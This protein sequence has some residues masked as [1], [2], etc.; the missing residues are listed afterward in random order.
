MKKMK[1]NASGS[2]SD[3]KITSV[4]F[5]SSLLLLSV[6]LFGISQLGRSNPRSMLA[7]AGAFLLI[8]S[9]L[10]LTIVWAKRSF[11]ILN[12]QIGELKKLA[13]SGSKNFREDSSQPLELADSLDGVVTTNAA[14]RVEPGGDDFDSSPGARSLYDPRRLPASRI[15]RGNTPGVIGRGAAEFELT[16]ISHRNFSEIFNSEPTDWQEPILTVV[17]LKCVESLGSS[18][19][20]KRLTPNTLDKLEDQRFRYLIIDE[21][22]LTTG[23]WA[24]VLETYRTQLFLSLNA[25]IR[26]LRASG[27]VVILKSSSMIFPFT[28]TLRESADVILPSKGVD[29]Q[30]AS[31]GGG[32][33]ILRKLENIGGELDV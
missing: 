30:D 10:G 8:A 28:L 9:F 1:I 33:E 20:Q 13:L 12:H 25:L 4:K 32:L 5:L 27:T 2:G 18:Y 19:I 17:P 23:L 14:N 21:D 26:S 6:L 11:S 7:G 31:T 24:G 15:E 29:F 22:E 16:D 3:K